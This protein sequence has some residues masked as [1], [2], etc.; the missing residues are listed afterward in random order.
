MSKLSSIVSI[1]NSGPPPNI[2]HCL[3]HPLLGISTYISRISDVITISLL[4]LFIDNIIIG[5]SCP[6]H[7][8]NVNQRTKLQ[9]I[10]DI[11]VIHGC[12]CIKPFPG[13]HNVDHAY[14][15]VNQQFCYYCKHQQDYN[16]PFKKSFHRRF[17]SVILHLFV[18][19]FLLTFVVCF[20]LT[21]IRIIINIRIIFP[22]ITLLTQLFVPNCKSRFCTLLAFPALFPPLLG[23]CLG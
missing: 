19:P 5:Q 20:Y 14:I 4:F 3:D 7:Q 13:I 2:M 8:Q 23:R 6:V 10:H 17:P 22:F 18:I 1:N 16:Q 9:N 12:L 21:A 15:S 11:I